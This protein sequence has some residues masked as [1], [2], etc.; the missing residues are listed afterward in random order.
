MPKEPDWNE[1]MRFA[2]S[3]AGKQLL[4]LLQQQGGDQ[5]RSAM[6]KAAAGDYTQAKKAISDFLT[7]PEAKALL[8]QLGGKP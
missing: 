3:P 6:D 5:L 7:T 8:E 1:A 2:Q 4:T